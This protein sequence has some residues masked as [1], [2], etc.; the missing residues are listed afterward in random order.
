MSISKGDC[1]AWDW[2]NGQGTGTVSK[3]YTSDVTVTIKG[4]E[5]KRNASDDCPA[6]LIKQDDG[7]EVLKSASE[8]EKT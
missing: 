7:D 8:I 6:Y 5:V 1:V 4:T 2:G 3:V